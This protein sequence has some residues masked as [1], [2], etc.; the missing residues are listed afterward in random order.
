MTGARLKSTYYDRVGARSAVMSRWPRIVSTAR[1]DSSPRAAQD[2]EPKGERDATR[3][4]ATRR[5]K[6][7]MLVPY[8]VQAIAASDTPI[9]GAQIEAHFQ[10]RDVPFIKGDSNKTAEAAPGGPAEAA[11]HYRP[12]QFFSERLPASTPAVNPPPGS[13]FPGHG[14]TRAQTLDGAPPS[15]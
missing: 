9:S 4:D 10:C 13:I 7:V 15:R 6:I 1:R 5:D 8:A 11:A 3:C 2:R 12:D 14:T